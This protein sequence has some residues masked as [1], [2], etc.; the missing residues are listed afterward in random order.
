MYIYRC[1]NSITLHAWVERCYLLTISTWT[2]NLQTSVYLHAVSLTQWA[3][4]V[5]N[6]LYNCLLLKQWA[7]Q[8]PPVTNKYKAYRQTY[9]VTPKQIQSSHIKIC[10]VRYTHFSNWHIQYLLNCLLHTHAV[11]QSTTHTIY[12]SS[13]INLNVLSNQQ[14]LQ[15][16]T[17]TKVVAFCHRPTDQLDFSSLSTCSNRLISSLF[18]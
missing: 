8:C 17:S 13:S 11:K 15:S 14:I 1:G 10:R 16:V 4:Y 2:T 7:E 5:L 6:S 9:Y 18:L 12:Q 3:A